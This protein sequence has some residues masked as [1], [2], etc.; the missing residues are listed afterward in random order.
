M[1]G[2]RVQL[3]GAARVTIGQTSLTFI[4]D[5]RYQLLAY[6]ACKAD[7]VAREQLA[8]L[9]WP[10]TGTQTARK[11][12]RHLIQ[13]TRG[14]E[15]L[16][17]FDAELEHLRW[18]V[19]TDVG[20]FRNALERSAW[21]EALALYRGPLLEG[22]RGDESPEFSDWLETER[23]VLRERWHAASL[24]QARALQERGAHTDAL[25]VLENLLERD[26]LDEDALDHFM[27]AATE[28]GQ[29]ATA[30]RSFEGFS[31]RLRQELNLPPPTNLE[32]LAQTIRAHEMAPVQVATAPRPPEASPSMRPLPLVTTP[33]VGRELV[34]AEL[35]NLLE[36]RE[37]RLITLIGTGGV[38]KTRIALQIAHERQE[39]LEVGFINLVPLSTPSA[40]PTAIAETINLS[41]QGKESPLVQV[42]DHIGERRMLLVIDNFEHLIA[43]TP[44]LNQLAQRCPNLVMLVTSR[45]ALGLLGEQVLPVEGFSVPE[46]FEI[47]L[48]EVSSLEAVQLFDQHA[49]RVRPDFRLVDANQFQVLEICRLVEGL[50]LGIELA[51]VWVRALSVGEIAH[52]IAQNLDFLSSRNTDRAERHRSVRAAFEYSWGLLTPEEQRTLRW[53]SVFRGG[54]SREAVRQAAHVPLPVLSS[55]IDK[56]LLA[57]NTRGRYRRHRLLHQYMQEKLAENPGEVAEATASH[58]Q[59]FFR[60]LQD[61]LDGIRGPNSR[62]ALEMLEVEFENI[63]AAWRWAIDRHQV[64]FLKGGTEALMRF[65]DARGRYLEAIEVLGEAITRLSEDDPEDRAAL[66]TLLV[67][68]SKFFERRGQYE[69]AQRLA[70]RGI[71]L[72]ESLD[73]RETMIWGL[74]SLGNV[75]RAAGD[76]DRALQY[77][78]Q[79][80]ASARALGNERLIAVC[81]GWVAISQD[82]LGNVAQ[83]KQHYREAIH[84]FKKL[85]NHIGAL[86]NLNNLGAVLIDLGELDEARS[87]LHE[88]LELARSAGELGQMPNILTA[89]GRCYHQQGDLENALKYTKQALEWAGSQV[90]GDV[91]NQV[92]LLITLAEISQV[93]SEPGR[94]RAYLSEALGKAWEA[95]ELPALMRALLAWVELRASDD[96]ALNLRLA[97]T[98]MRHS[99]THGRDRE[100]ARGLLEARGLIATNLAEPLELDDLVRQIRFG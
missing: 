84:L 13:R 10:E 11:N 58:A 90:T 54:F 76:F 38:G 97:E 20:E 82:D 36:R 53:L 5:K 18:R 69:S 52:E 3:L 59:Y 95:Q 56:S 61:G 44:Y 81:L 29:R 74:G 72:L 1:D 65:F 94:A 15:W 32:Q 35:T 83:A 85:G 71:A 48:E 88:A 47:D 67:H 98:V 60:L 39:H 86:F 37:H 14:L 96:A 62:A 27:R 63:R 91:E 43:G 55:L 89:L 26:P 8:Y 9:F 19:Q 50:P 34:L 42:I 57:L 21:N 77:R 73:E 6:L 45:E 78:Q 40:I 75:V 28:A 23:E 2:A 79:A 24:H 17:G 30:L 92:D 93:Q 4:D 7:W 31:R 68:Q 25:R 64:Q 51:A 70:R 66:G 49:R 41:L 99:A 16:E 46:R 100:R 33:F 22:F 87:L 12:L 80:L